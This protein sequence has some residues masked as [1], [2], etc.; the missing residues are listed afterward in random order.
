VFR[1]CSEDFVIPIRIEDEDVVIVITDR[2]GVELRYIL[3]TLSFTGTL[4]N[5]VIGRLPPTG[6]VPA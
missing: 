6:D 1:P 4:A 5:P 2:K 3:G